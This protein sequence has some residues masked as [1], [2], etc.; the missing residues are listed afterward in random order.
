MISVQINVAQLLKLGDRLKTISRDTRRKAAFALNK[1]GAQMMMV[2]AQKLATDAGL[3][4]N[5]VLDLM[6]VKKATAND[7]TYEIDASAVLP[8]AEEEGKWQRPWD[9][10]RSADNSKRLLKIV[11][12]HD[13]RVCPI[14]EEAAENSP[15]TAAEIQNMQ[16]KWAHYTPPYE[17]EGTRTNLIHPNCRCIVTPWRKRAAAT[18]IRADS[19]SF[20]AEG[21]GKKIGRTLLQE[22]KATIKAT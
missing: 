2:A 20:I 8:L 7:L 10:R 13:E 14:C 17:V 1:A 4:L 21:I 3:E 15:Y 5:E 16:A 9:T 6:T 11:D 18:T 22:F 19:R 12:Y